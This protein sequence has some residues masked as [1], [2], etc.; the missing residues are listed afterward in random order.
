MTKPKKKNALSG[1]VKKKQP[2]RPKAANP[3]DKE[4]KISNEQSSAEKTVA[5]PVNNQG[6]HLLPANKDSATSIKATGVTV[7]PAAAI[8]KPTP[9]SALGLLGGYSDSSENS[10]DND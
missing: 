8:S 9:S 10:S 1:L 2:D 7:V 5:V 3:Q 4:D 6:P